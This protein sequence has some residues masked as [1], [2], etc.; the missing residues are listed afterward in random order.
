MKKRIL[1]LSISALSFFTASDLRAQGDAATLLRGG[2]SDANLLMNAYMGPMMKSFG[3]GLNGGWFQTAKPHG[4]GGF[5][6][7]FSGNL[8][9]APDA[10]KIYDVATL[11]LNK[12]RLKSG[13]SSE[14]P[15]V[16]GSGDGPTVE[17]VEKSPFTGN[18]TPL[19]SFV[20]PPGAGLTF[21][22]V[23]TM[24]FQVGVGFGTELGIRYLPTIKAGDISIGLFGFAVK[25]DFK[26]WIPGIK[27]MPFD[28]SAMFGYTSLDAEFAFGKNGLQ[29][30][31]DTNVYKPAGL[32]AFDNQKIVFTGSAWT[33]NVLI[34]KKLGPLT[35]YLGL[36]YQHSNV[37]L[38]LKGDYPITG[39]NDIATAT[40]PGPGQ[41]K[42][43][44]VITITDPIDISGKNSGVRATVGI[45]LKLLLLTLHGDYTFAAYN[46]ASVGVGLNLQS[47]VPFKL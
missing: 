30:D 8:A 39:P 44:K 46:M 18:D 3:A 20:L 9:F 13:E 29:P 25:H 28:L 11:G 45:R 40:S 16:F 33:I 17:L 5:D 27:E 15:T 41:G 19:T 43:A 31:A 24:Q 4:I 6:L 26:Q 14:A 37:S 34:S 1:I 7:T 21:F 32:P 36:G 12:L 42:P 22:P 2:V 35:P 23:P 38:A 10:D 47:I